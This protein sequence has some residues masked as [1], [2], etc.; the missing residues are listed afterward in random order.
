MGK[1]WELK[2]NFTALAYNMC[3]LHCRGNVKSSSFQGCIQQGCPTDGP[4]DTNSLWEVKL[5]PQAP[6]WPLLPHCSGCNSSQS[7]QASLPPGASAFYTSLWGATVHCDMLRVHCAIGLSMGGVGEVCGLGTHG[8]CWCSLYNMQP[9]W[10]GSQL[11]RSWTALV[12]STCNQLRHQAA[13]G[14]T[15]CL[16]FPMGQCS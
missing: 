6:T 13:Y 3:H 7:L 12:Y 1:K 4:K 15:A 14:E 16:W 11:L 10:C 5:Q 9:Y 8:P 2:F